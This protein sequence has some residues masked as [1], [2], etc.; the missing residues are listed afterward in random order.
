MCYKDTYAYIC[1]NS[2]SKCHL[3]GY[4]ISFKNTEYILAN[5]FCDH[6]EHD[7]WWYKFKIPLKKPSN[8]TKE[9]IL[10]R[11]EAPRQYCISKLIGIPMNELWTVLFDCNLSRKKCEQKILFSKRSRI[12]FQCT[13]LPNLLLL[14]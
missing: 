1:S 5:F 12:L 9:Y 6:H 14:C 2:D 10:Q 8:P 3:L 11:D 4:R 7:A 13:D